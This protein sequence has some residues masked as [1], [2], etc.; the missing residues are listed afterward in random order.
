MDYT[1]GPTDLTRSES[2][3]Y[4]FL[5]I[6]LRDADHEL[7]LM[8]TSNNRMGESLIS[9]TFFMAGLLVPDG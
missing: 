2:Y 9:V 7:Q 3:G 5:Q 1:D 6:V 8:I 4:Y